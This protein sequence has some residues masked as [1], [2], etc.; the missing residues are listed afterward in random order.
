MRSLLISAS[1]RSTRFALSLRNFATLDG[2]TCA[3]SSQDVLKHD[4]N[5][6]QK[7]NPPLRK[8][9][10]LNGEKE[11]CGNSEYQAEFARNPELK[12]DPSIWNKLYRSAKERDRKDGVRDVWK[13]LTGYPIHEVPVLYDLDI[14]KDLH[15]EQ[16]IGYMR[17][18]NDAGIQPPKGSLK[19]IGFEYHNLEF[20]SAS[21]E[22]LVEAAALNFDV[23]LLHNTYNVL[24]PKLCAK[25]DVDLALKWHRKLVAKG[26]PPRKKQDVENLRRMLIER[27]LWAA[28]LEVKKSVVAENVDVV[29]PSMSTAEAENDRRKALQSFISKLDERV[30]VA[31]FTP[32]IED[33]TCARFFATSFFSVE[34]VMEGMS[35]F[36]LVK[37][38]SLSIREIV[39]R[40]ILGNHCDASLARQYFARMKKLGLRCDTRYGRLLEYLSN[41][42]KEVLLYSIVASDFH[43]DMYDNLKFQ[44]S[45]LRSQDPT[46]VERTWAVLCFEMR[47][48]EAEI[49]NIMLRTNLENIELMVADG[50]PI[51]LESRTSLLES[52]YIKRSPWI[53]ESKLLT[54]AR[55]FL[56]L[57]Y[58]TAPEWKRV[59][60]A[61]FYVIRPYL[62][63][64]FEAL[65]FS[66]RC[67]ELFDDR[68]VTEIIRWYLK[69]GAVE[70]DPTMEAMLGGIRVLAALR[71]QGNAINI[72]EP[73]EANLM[74]L[75]GDTPIGEFVD[76][77]KRAIARKLGTAEDFI[78][79]MKEIW[80][81]DLWPGMSP[82]EVKEEIFKIAAE[83]IHLRKQKYNGIEAP[84][85]HTGA[86]NPGKLKWVRDQMKINDEAGKLKAT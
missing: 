19:K 5:N 53:A 63:R 28:A 6:V 7:E 33:H 38:G 84:Q 31:S 41:E 4:E 52:I 43:P 42:G 40:T 16:L 85:S 18:L 80:G 46:V 59:M 86:Y 32:E 21:E 47:E 13:A 23:K 2:P 65:L 12:R 77:K 14:W 70:Y 1:S 62:R 75:F 29:L 17:K 78:I 48:Q 25:G 22:E 3:A 69:L 82:L 11:Q 55:V 73:C 67:P 24:I 39:K 8:E 58:I 37:F 72:R 50:V 30:G 54:L 34:F 79:A 27:R 20:I 81:P 49:R 64:E 51:T 76:L 74:S 15:G 71:D 45:L 36:G 83:K 56:R 57:P 60:T 68:L 44:E 61:F 35:L 9:Q 26:D 66:I 10:Y